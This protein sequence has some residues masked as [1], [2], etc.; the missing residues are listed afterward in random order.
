M[1]KIYTD[2]ACKGN[3][4][5]GGWGA[6]ITDGLENKEIYGGEKN[7][8]NNRMELMAVIMALESIEKEQKITI[9]TDSTYVQKGISE[10][11]VNWKRNGWKSSN[12]QPVKNQDLWMR[13]DGSNSSLITWEWVKGHSGHIENDRADYLANLGVHSASQ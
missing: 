3:P 11:I 2:G 10:W 8:T 5:D 4:G 6:L 1:I 7:T 9:F 13:L 12:K